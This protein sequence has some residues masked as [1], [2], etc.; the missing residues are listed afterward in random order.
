MKR[1]GLT[2][3]ML[4]LVTALPISSQA[5]TT[6]AAAKPASGAQSML[7]HFKGAPKS[8]KEQ[9]ERLKATTAAYEKMTDAQ[10]DA[11]RQQ[12]DAKRMQVVERRKAMIAQRRQ[13]PAQVTAPAPAATPA[14][15]TAPVPAAR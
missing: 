9:I 6:Q 8:R 1:Y 15:A 10:W 2:L 14:P 7:P 13:A 4:I 3:S 11:M 12:Q 5:A